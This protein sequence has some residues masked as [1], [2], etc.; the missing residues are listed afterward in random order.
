MTVCVLELTLGFVELA[1]VIAPP[2]LVAVR[3]VAPSAAT[4]IAD[5]FKVG[6]EQNN[7]FN[8]REYDQYVPCRIKHNAA[9]CIY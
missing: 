6:Q 8:Y 1:A 5:P 3:A 9:W 7:K 4:T 2:F